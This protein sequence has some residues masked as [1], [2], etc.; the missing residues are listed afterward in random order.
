MQR[1]PPVVA[2]ANSKKRKGTS[3]TSKGVLPLVATCCRR[4]L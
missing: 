4:Q 3:G 2:A 1:A